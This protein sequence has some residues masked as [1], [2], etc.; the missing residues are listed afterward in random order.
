MDVTVTL[1]NH[2]PQGQTIQ[3]WGDVSLPDYSPYPHNPVLRPVSVTLAGGES[4]IIP[5][6]QVV[7]RN[8]PAGDY[9]YQLNIGTYPDALYDDSF[10]VTVVR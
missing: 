10:P 9:A 7:P 1:T 4:K 8:A 6:S 3:Y 5:V 2:S